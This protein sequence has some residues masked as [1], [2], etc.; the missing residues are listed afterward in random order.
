MKNQS[1]C[2]KDEDLPPD[3]DVSYPP[4]EELRKFLFLVPS[5]CFQG[6]FGKLAFEY[7]KLSLHKQLSKRQL[8]RVV[9]L[10]EFAVSHQDLFDCF[11]KIDEFSTSVIEGHI[12][13]DDENEMACLREYLIVGV[14]KIFNER[15]KSREGGDESYFKF[16]KLG[17]KTTLHPKN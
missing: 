6:R 15:Y 11:I 7:F 1:V 16:F 2:R 5:E 12:L 4:P 3:I 9:E 10:T 13:S 14:Q 17:E 8:D